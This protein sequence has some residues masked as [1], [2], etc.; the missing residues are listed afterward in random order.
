MKLAILLLIPLFLGA[1]KSAELARI[2][3]EPHAEKRA[4][5]ALDYADEALRRAR[6]AYAKGDT[7]AT[8]AHLQDLEQSVELADSSL[9]DTGKNPSRSPKNFKSAELKIREILRKLDGFRE[10]MSV[11]DRP[12]IERVLAEVQKIHDTLLD[13]IMG[14]RK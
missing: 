3:G 12:V 14:K 7:A 13:S 9:K 10:E 5:A 6:D 4:R 1:D 11:A 2:E 8:A